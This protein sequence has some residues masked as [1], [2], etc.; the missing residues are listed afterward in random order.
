MHGLV[1]TDSLATL[2]GAFQAQRSAADGEGAVALDAGTAVYVIIVAVQLA[3]ARG[4]GR[5]ASPINLDDA[6]TLHAL[7]CHTATLHVDDAASHQ[8]S[9][10]GLD[11]VAG[12]V[13]DVDVVARSEQDIVIAG[14]AALA[15]GQ[16]LQMATAAEEQFAL[17]EERRLHVLVGWRVI[18]AAVL[19]RVPC[20]V[21]Q[22][23]VATLLALAVDGSTSGV[24]DIHPVEPQGIL[25]LAIELE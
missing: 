18:A 15:V 9:V 21:G 25:A 6:L 3:G 14:D 8:D 12:S 7:G 11:A 13:L 24:G 10:I 5:E 17:A 1:A 16:H 22:F 4:D 2:A 20:A 19:Q 23:D